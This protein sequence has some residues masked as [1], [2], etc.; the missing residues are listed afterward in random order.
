MNP[1][2][3]MRRCNAAVVLYFIK[4]MSFFNP[5]F[6]VTIKS[7]LCPAMYSTS[8]LYNS[9]PPGVFTNCLTTRYLFSFHPLHVTMEAVLPSASEKV[10]A[11][12][13]RNRIDFI[14]LVFYFGKISNDGVYIKHTYVASVEKNRSL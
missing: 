2:S 6:L 3:N 5:F 8:M 12:K 13:G 1:S 7:G 9:A 11:I 10:A 14:L 4:S